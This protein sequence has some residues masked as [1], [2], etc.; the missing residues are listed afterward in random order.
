M[1][2]VNFVLRAVLETWL[3]MFVFDGLCHGM[4]FCIVWNVNIVCE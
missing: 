3:S 4:R 2:A 1:P